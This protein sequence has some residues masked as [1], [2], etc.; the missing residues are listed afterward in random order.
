[1]RRFNIKEELWEYNSKEEQ[2][3]EGRIGSATTARKSK[4][5]KVGRRDFFKTVFALE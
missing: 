5:E 4:W 1:M 3:G 2:V